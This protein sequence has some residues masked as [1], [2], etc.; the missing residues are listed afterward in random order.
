MRLL[1]LP[2]LLGAL[3]LAQHS[4]ITPPRGSPINDMPILGMGMFGVPK[5]NTT[6]V[7][8]AALEMG[9]RHFDTAAIYGNEKEVGVGLAAA[10]AKTGLKRED[11]WITTKVTFFFWKMGPPFFGRS[12]VCVVRVGCR[13]DDG[14]YSCGMIVIMTLKRPCRSRCRS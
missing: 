2:S 1:A 11:V 5:P 7:M 14:G 4:P 3:A 10:L 8:I 13:S 9:Y 6:A 12:T